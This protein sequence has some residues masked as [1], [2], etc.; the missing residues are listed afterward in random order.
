MSG[1]VA[2]ILVG[3]IT[4]IKVAAYGGVEGAATDIGFT[5]EGVKLS[6]PREYYDVKVDQIVGTIK[7][8]VTDRKFI[9]DLV[10]SESTLE[11]LA[12]VF[13]LPTTAV[14]GDTLTIDANA[15]ETNRTIYLNGEA[16]SGGTRKVTLHKCVMIGTGEHTYAKDGERAVTVQIEALVDTLNSNEFGTIVDA[17]SDA[18][19]PTIALASPIDGGN[20]SA[21]GTTAIVLQ[22][23][24]AG[25]MDESTIVYGSGDGATVMVFDIE[26]PL[27]ITLKA[28]TIAYNST[29]KQITFTPTAAWAGAANNYQVI[30][31]TGLS[32]EAGNH[33][34]TVFIGHLV[35]A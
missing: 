11:N 27:A 15:T 17:S 33:L 2:N 14:A 16:E 28:G 8:R 25:N 30:V 5:K 35:T 20:L 13:D 19:A 9:I 4:N 12:K 18:I 24:E 23:T 1:T 7:K 3:G 21:T 26:N 22:I 31:T 6:M 34:A 29:T 32:D 10:L